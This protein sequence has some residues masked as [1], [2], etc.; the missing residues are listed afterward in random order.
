M[1]RRR[2]NFRRIASPSGSSLISHAPHALPSSS[3][4]PSSSSPGAMSSRRQTTRK[5][6]GTAAGGKPHRSYLLKS[7]KVALESD[8][9]RN[10]AGL[11]RRCP[12]CAEKE[13]K[14][15]AP[16]VH[17]SHLLECPARIRAAPT[18]AGVCGKC[19]A[20]SQ[21]PPNLNY[22]KGHADTCPE[23]KAFKRAAAAPR[24]VSAILHERSLLRANP[25]SLSGVCCAPVR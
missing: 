4:S 6:F 18:P 22:K 13:A 24:G 8:G 7:R 25:G 17:S 14:P 11:A 20:A 12:A 19:K 3:A 16:K 10:A 2:H 1:P 21:D 15:L 23:S 5:G 9:R